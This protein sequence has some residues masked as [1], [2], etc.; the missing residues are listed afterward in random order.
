MVEHWIPK[1]IQENTFPLTILFRRTL[2]HRLFRPNGTTKAFLF[3]SRLDS[4]S[5]IAW[6]KKQKRMKRK[7]KKNSHSSAEAEK[8]Q[9]TSKPCANFARQKQKHSMNMKLLNKRI[10]IHLRK[11]KKIVNEIF[12]DFIFVTNK[13]NEEWRIKTNTK[14]RIK[15]SYKNENNKYACC[16]FKLLIVIVKRR[17]HV[18]YTDYTVY[19]WISWISICNK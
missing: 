7:K 12:I 14:T 4:Y 8:L 10:Q 6:Q 15:K 3:N 19:E 16:L 13:R 9:T 2:L 18:G 17:I 11:K 5:T 1:K